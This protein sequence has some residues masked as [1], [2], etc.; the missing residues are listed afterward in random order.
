M[1]VQLLNQKQEGQNYYNAF[2]LLSNVTEQANYVSKH[3]NQMK[4][5]LFKLLLTSIANIVIHKIVF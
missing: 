3:L 5:L 1:G 2:Y 4:K